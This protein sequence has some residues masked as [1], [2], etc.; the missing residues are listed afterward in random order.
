MLWPRR[1]VREELV[2][3]E[4]ALWATVGPDLRPLV[5]AFAHQL[6]VAIARA[7]GDLDD[8]ERAWLAQRFPVAAL[9]QQGFVSMT[10]D[11]F[12]FTYFQSAA[13]AFAELPARLTPDE[14]GALVHE[15]TLAAVAS[16]ARQGVIGIEERLLLDQ[17]ARLLTPPG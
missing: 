14:K 4:S 12:T 11:T 16:R 13:R 5:L 6:A 15:L 9:R 17:A 3:P 1:R 2:T 7:D 8:D 10:K